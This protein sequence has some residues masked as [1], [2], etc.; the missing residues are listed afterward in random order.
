MTAL[1][2]PSVADRPLR[3]R[4]TLAAVW[5]TEDKTGRRLTQEEPSRWPGRL[6][7]LVEIA[8]F[9]ALIVGGAFLYTVTP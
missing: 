9:L 4:L 8:A 3:S 2:W 7:R 1:R 6:E 5:A